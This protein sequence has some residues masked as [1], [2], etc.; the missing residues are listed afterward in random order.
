MTINEAFLESAVDW[1]DTPG[2]SGGS[3]V[4]DCILPHYIVSPE[5]RHRAPQVR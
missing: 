4:E 1:P 3:V 5:G 2:Q